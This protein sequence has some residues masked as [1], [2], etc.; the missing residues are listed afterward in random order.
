MIN[1]VTLILLFGIVVC[2]CNK[3]RNDVKAKK[4]VM[5]LSHWDFEKQGNIHL[6]GQWEFY[7]N[8]LLTS[9]DFKR[10]IKDTVRYIEVHRP[11]GLVADGPE[12]RCSF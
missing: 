3:M 12:E 9:E 2:S 4:G 7:W 11:Q 6:D 5:D 8:R 10:G 1:R